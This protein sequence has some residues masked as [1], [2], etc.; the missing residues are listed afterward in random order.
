MKGVKLSCGSDDM[1]L[2]ETSRA[3]IFFKLFFML[4]RK[5]FFFRIEDLTSLT[6]NFP[7]SQFSSPIPYFHFFFKHKV[8]PVQEQWRIHPRC[9]SKSNL[10][11]NIILINV[12]RKHIIWMSECVKYDLMLFIHSYLLIVL[13]SAFQRIQFITSLLVS[14]ILLK[15]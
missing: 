7:L 2:S 12:W 11:P 13:Q 5:P 9:F 10:V 8:K 4:L 3:R 1:E 14:Q 6:C 15:C